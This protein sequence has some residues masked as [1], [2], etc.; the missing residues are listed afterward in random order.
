MEAVDG[1]PGGE[2]KRNFLLLLIGWLLMIA[3]GVFINH[4]SPLRPVTVKPVWL[5]ARDL[6]ANTHLSAEDLKTPE[7]LTD[8]SGLPPLD[9]LVGK[10]LWEDTPAGADVHV[11]ALRDRPSIPDTAVTF[12][13]SLDQAEIGLAEVLAPGD[14]V[15]V[16]VVGE[17]ESD[18][19]CSGPV[20]VITISMG[21][22]PEERWLLLDVAGQE[23]ELGLILA[24]QQHFVV[25][26]APTNAANP[27][28]PGEDQ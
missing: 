25:R 27:G 1:L 20:G 3:G 7:G 10:Y 6:P 23:A 24:A 18:Q 9:G 19:P 16:C 4:Y 11:S 2:V 8:T 22:N 12:L 13:Y 26:L 15:S 17:T 14:W 21:V 5:A 28:P